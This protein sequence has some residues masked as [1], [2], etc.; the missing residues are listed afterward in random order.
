MTRA[1]TAV[2][3]P[4]ASADHPTLTHTST[5]PVSTA[6]FKVE[7][8][9]LLSLSLSVCVCLFQFPIIVV[10]LKSCASSCNLAKS[11]D[12]GK[13][14]FLNFYFMTFRVHVILHNFINHGSLCFY[15]LLIVE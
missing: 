6:A 14:F 1:G 11:R 7:L 3:Q 9:S 2:D 12:G 10:S 8:S 5:S 15:E 13:Y 4:T